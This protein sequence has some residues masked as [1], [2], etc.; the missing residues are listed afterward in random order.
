MLGLRVAINRYVSD[1]P[2]PG[3]VECE[4]VDANGRHWLFVEKTAI[5]AA[6]LD[7]R[8]AYPQPGVI[9]CE[10]VHRA[11]NAVGREVIVV[12]T[13]RPWG[14]ESIEGVTRFEVSVET[15]LEF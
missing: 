5:S 15:L 8:S 9:A 3:L 7:G 2:Q 1:D 10:V 6:P 14:V 4:L 12:D 13:N 11:R